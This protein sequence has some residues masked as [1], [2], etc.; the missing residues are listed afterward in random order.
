MERIRECRNRS[1]EKQMCKRMQKLKHRKV[2][3]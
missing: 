2:K 1:A 3:E